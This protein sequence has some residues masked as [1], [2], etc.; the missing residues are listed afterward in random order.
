MSMEGSSSEILVLSFYVGKATLVEILAHS[1]DG[2]RDTCKNAEGTFACY[3]QTQAAT[4]ATYPI[5]H[6][7]PFVCP[8]LER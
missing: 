2:C 5:L 1:D 4:A 7:S 6:D 3:V 8:N